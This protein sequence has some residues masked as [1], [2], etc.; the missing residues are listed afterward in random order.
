MICHSRAGGHFGS[1]RDMD[2]KKDDVVED[3]GAE[4][5]VSAQEPSENTQK[6]RTWKLSVIFLCFYGFMT[7]L[8][9]GEAFITPNLL[10]SEKNFT[11]EQVG[12]VF[13]SVSTGAE[14]L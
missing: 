4:A 6:I 12:A 2:L 14:L 9:P 1:E 8:K 7:S 5:A 11:R 13:L 10:S 3:G